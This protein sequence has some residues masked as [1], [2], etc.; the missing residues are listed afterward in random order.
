MKNRYFGIIPLFTFI[1]ASVVCLIDGEAGRILWICNISTLIQGAGM[2]FLH[3]RWVWIGTMWLIIGLPFWILDGLLYDLV[4]TPQAIMMH[5]GCSLLGLAFLWREESI[6]NSWWQAYV[7][8][9]ILYVP[10]RLFADPA[11]N[12]N[13]SFS[14][15]PMSAGLFSDY[16]KYFLFANISFLITLYLVDALIKHIIAR[17]EIT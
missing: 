9:L 7:I 17:K 1:Y 15:H 16:T 13:L 11:L 6:R 14:I 5:V 3:T 4:F 12:V 10:S 2:L 8:L